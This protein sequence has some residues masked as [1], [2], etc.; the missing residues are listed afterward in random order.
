MRRAMA[1]GRVGE[2]QHHEAEAA[3]LDQQ[4]GG[5]QRVLRIA[6]A[7]HPEDAIEIHAGFEGRGRI[8]RARC[9][10]PCAAFAALRGLAEKGENQG[11]A[12]GRF[13]AAD[14]GERATGN[15][16][17]DEAVDGRDAG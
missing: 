15:A 6:P 17:G 5:F 10:D 1:S 16:S 12:A 4:V 7:I 11:G 14:F 3:R 8:E 13:G 2:I 9:I